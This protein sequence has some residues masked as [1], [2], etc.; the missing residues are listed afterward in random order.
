MTF[1]PLIFSGEDVTT[2]TVAHPNRRFTLEEFERFCQLNPEAVIELEP[3]GSLT[4]MSPVSP[5]S[6][7]AENEFGTDLGLYARKHGGSAFSSST[8]FTL[9]DGSVRSPDASYLSARKMKGLTKEELK[10]FTAV[11]P[12]F[13]V[14]VISPSDRTKVTDQKMRDKWVA[15]GVPLAWMVDVEQEKVWIYRSDLSVDVHTDFE[16]PLT[17][18]DILPGFVFDL[19]VLMR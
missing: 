2:L 8:G 13:V 1:P 16:V 9:P 14:E 7:N 5:Y 4:V 19:R 3:D 11:V 17:G 15:N 6:G 18:E 10:H 12:D